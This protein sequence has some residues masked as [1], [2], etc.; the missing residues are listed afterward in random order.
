LLISPTGSGS[1]AIC[2][3]PSAMPAITESV[4]ASRSTKAGSW[5][6]ARAA[7]RSFAL[8]AFSA[9]AASRIAAA[10][11]CSARFFAA[12][13]ARAISREARRARRPRSAT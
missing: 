7:S 5:P 1:A 10:V 6:A 4:S 13:P 2:A 11:A 9:G 8:A 12:V 3:S